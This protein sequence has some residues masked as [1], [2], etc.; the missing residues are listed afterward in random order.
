MLFRGERG[1]IWNEMAAGGVLLVVPAVIVMLVARK[2]FV[3]GITLGA[4]D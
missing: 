4:I 2:Y 1:V 3:K